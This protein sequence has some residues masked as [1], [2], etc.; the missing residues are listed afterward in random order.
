MFYVDFKQMATRRLGGDNSSSFEALSTNTLWHNARNPA[1]LP[2]KYSD[3]PHTISAKAL[4]AELATMADQHVVYLNEV[5][6]ISDADSAEVTAMLLD[7]VWTKGFA[8]KKE[9]SLA[10]R[11]QQ[12]VSE[13]TG[14]GISTESLK[15]VLDKS[16]AVKN[17]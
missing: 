6:L 4:A 5:P 8:I 2:A 12:Y 15:S 1:G 3:A 17:S 9:T 7:G 10:M 11:V 16:L 13:C 14:F